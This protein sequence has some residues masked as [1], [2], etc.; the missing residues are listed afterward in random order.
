[1]KHTS[2]QTPNLRSPWAFFD[3]VR[4]LL[5]WG[6]SLHLCQMLTLFTCRHDSMVSE[7]VFSCISTRLVFLIKTYQRLAKSRFEKFLMSLTE[8]SGLLLFLEDASQK[9]D[10]KSSEIRA[11]TP[12]S[13][14]S[15]T[16]Q[17]RRSKINDR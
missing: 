10:M 1:M 17:R 7:G 11:G 12:R 3:I 9:A 16:E 13:K 5:L 15:A 14:H 4:Y 8:N 6:F 2:V